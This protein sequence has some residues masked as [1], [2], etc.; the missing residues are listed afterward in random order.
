[1]LHDSMDDM[2]SCTLERKFRNIHE[3]ELS[4]LSLRP[5]R[6]TDIRIILIHGCPHREHTEPTHQGCSVALT[7]P[8]GN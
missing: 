5:Q 2:I 8:N 7:P 6:F 4:Q 3:Y 1:M